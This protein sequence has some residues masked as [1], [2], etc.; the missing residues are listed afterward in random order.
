MIAVP[1]RF[2][3]EEYLLL[4][5]DNPVRHEYRQGLVYAMA[6]G[7]SNHSRISV[8]FL[9]LV[10]PQLDDT[11]C[12]L[13]N[14]DMKV[15]HADEFFYYPDAFVTCDPRDREDRYIKRHPKLVVE[16]LSQS[17]QDFDRDKKFLD[18]QKIDSLEEYIL[19]SQET[20]Q[21]E[22]R[23]RTTD[24][25]WETEIYAVGDRVTLTSLDLEFDLERL[26][27]NLD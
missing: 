14:G 17:T 5:R 25:T 26:Y 20:Q 3:P 27:R 12:R 24:N 1:N 7:T 16:V 13:Y 15:S 22:C 10:N 9:S 6:G 21:V 8:N 19:I 18:Y 11:P 4:D 23:R 2:S